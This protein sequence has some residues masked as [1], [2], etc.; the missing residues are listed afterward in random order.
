M[1][2]L[3]RWKI[4]GA[5]WWFEG[6]CLDNCYDK[7]PVFLLNKVKCDLFCLPLTWIWSL[8]SPSEPAPSACR[9]ATWPGPRPPTKSASKR[10]GSVLFELSSDSREG[11]R[12]SVKSYA[13]LRT[14]CYY[15]SNGFDGSKT[16][17]DEVDGMPL[18]LGSER[19]TIW[20]EFEF[21]IAP[22]LAEAL[23]KLEIRKFEK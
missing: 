12:L 10:F 20:I 4:L 15:L 14:I 16:G 21:G 3:R 2:N 7:G 13:W 18:L 5:A 23:S 17:C 1:I 22:R 9:P 6:L 8:T 11:S 19:W